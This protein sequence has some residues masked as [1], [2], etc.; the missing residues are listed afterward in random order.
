MKRFAYLFVVLAACGGKDT[1]TTT[2]PVTTTG[3]DGH[4][5]HGKLTPELTA[6]HDVLSPLWHSEAPTRMKDTCAALPEFGT[7]SQAVKAAAPPTTVEAAAWS[8]AGLD[9]EASVSGLQT[10]C[11][12][13]DEGAFSTAFSTVHDAFHHAMELIVGKH[14]KG[15]KMGD[16]QGEGKHMGPGHEAGAGGGGSHH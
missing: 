4:S 14:E 1:S 7:R 10:A 6:F 16:H 5:E 3:G 9:L 11:G 13:T 8:K 2:M 12:G 15:D